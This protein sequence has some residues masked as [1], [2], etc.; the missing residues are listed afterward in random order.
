MEECYR[1]RE[2]SQGGGFRTALVG[3]LDQSGNGAKLETRFE[4]G[5]TYRLNSK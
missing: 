3:V 1:G 2:L 4:G 5:E